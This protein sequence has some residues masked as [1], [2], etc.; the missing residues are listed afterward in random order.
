[1]KINCLTNKTTL[2]SFCPQGFAFP[3]LAPGALQLHLSL[4]EEPVGL[5]EL[6]PALQ[7]G[8]L[9][10]LNLLCNIL[11]LLEGPLQLQLCKE[12]VGVAINEVPERRELN[13]TWNS[14]T[15]MPKIWEPVEVLDL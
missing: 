2:K 5:S 14:D 1:M 6:G 7:E 3:H 15:K 12:A 8:F 4:C 11:L 10:T 13:T 9:C